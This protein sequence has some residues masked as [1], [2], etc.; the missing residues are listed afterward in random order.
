MVNGE[1]GVVRVKDKG[2]GVETRVL[3]PGEVYEENVAEIVKRP[4]DQEVDNRGGDSHDVAAGIDEHANDDTGGQ[5]NVDKITAGGDGHD[6]I[7][8]GVIHVRVRDQGA[9]AQDEA[10]A[11]GGG[12]HDGAGG[13]WDIR[14][15]GGEG[16]KAAKDIAAC[17]KEEVRGAGVYNV[18][19][20]PI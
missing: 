1:A 13:Q 20:H 6:S 4:D 2:G 16:D 19:T 12:D 17:I 9:H 18:H 5:V 10:Q 15:Q 7:A 8:A 11:A 3:K 14:V